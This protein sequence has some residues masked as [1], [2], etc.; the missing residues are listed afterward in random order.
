M[1][2]AKEK[3]LSGMRENGLGNFRMID[4]QRVQAPTLYAR[5]CAWSWEAEGSDPESP[6]PPGV[7]QSTVETCHS[8][9]QTEYELL[10]GTVIYQEGTYEDGG[11]NA[12]P[13]E[14]VLAEQ[15]K[16]GERK[17]LRIND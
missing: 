13:E 4:A 7:P 11:G 1:R 15:E 5:D 16:A 8:D 9:S 17:I 12:K 3:L 14:S 10:S 6:S 2:R